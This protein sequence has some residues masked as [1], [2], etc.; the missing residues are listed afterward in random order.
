MQGRTGRYMRV[1]AEKGGKKK[2]EK[3]ERE[4]REEKEIR[5]KKCEMI[6]KGKLPV[7]CTLALC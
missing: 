4:K 5:N 3:K 2:K 7:I 6:L 1:Y